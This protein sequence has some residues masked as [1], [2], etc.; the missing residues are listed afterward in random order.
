LAGSGKKLSLQTLD[1]HTSRDTKCKVPPRNPSRRTLEPGKT[2]REYPT[3]MPT[4]A[5]SCLLDVH[6]SKIEWC[7]GRHAHTLVSECPINSDAN[8][9]NSNN[10]CKAK[11]PS[12][13]RRHHG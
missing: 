13:D 11:H 5:P 6:P 12:A 1:V 10:A 8:S 4:N 9:V 3:P 2:Y 7:R